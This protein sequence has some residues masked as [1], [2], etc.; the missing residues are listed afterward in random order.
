[1][2]CNIDYI[3][4]FKSKK[5]QLDTIKNLENGKIDILIGTHRIV[6]K[7]IKFMNL[8][9]LIIDEEQKFGVNIK[10]KIKLIKRY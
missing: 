2:P 9:L 8:G 4:R 5:E 7:D 3:N 10:D 6:S 1:M